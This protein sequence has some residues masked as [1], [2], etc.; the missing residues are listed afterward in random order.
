[1]IQIDYREVKWNPY[2]EVVGCI[3]KRSSN[4]NRCVLSW[5]DR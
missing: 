4:P 5:M 3:I 1:M 2:A